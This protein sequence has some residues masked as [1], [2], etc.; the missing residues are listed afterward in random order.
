MNKRDLLPDEFEYKKYL[1]D[2]K[3]SQLLGIKAPEKPNEK[4]ILPTIFS[5][6]PENKLPFP[7]E[8]DDLCRLHYIARNRKVLTI[9]GQAYWVSK[10]KL[11]NGPVPSILYWL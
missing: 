7:A 9:L 6:D 1:E 8:F 2:N 5:V 4:L 3:L 10:I 11:S